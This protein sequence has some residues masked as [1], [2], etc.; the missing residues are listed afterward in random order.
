MALG[1][2]STVAQTGRSDNSPFPDMS[3]APLVESSVM[4]IS[5]ADLVAALARVSHDTWRRQANQDK[6]TPLKELSEEVHR[7]DVER[8]ED[9]VAELERLGVWTEEE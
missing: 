5:R 7:H 4:T 9:T 8:A 2:A 1:P 6:G 3:G